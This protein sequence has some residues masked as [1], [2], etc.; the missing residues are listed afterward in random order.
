M[1]SGRVTLPT[2]VSFDYALLFDNAQE[3]TQDCRRKN[4]DY[5][6]A[7]GSCLC[8]WVIQSSLFNDDAEY[9]AVLFKIHLKIEY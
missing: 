8:E 6:Q 4:R 9:H 7:H 1:K 3:N 2:D 5:N